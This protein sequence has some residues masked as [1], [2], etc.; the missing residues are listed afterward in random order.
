M[1][2]EKHAMFLVK[3]HIYFCA[4]TL[5]VS[6]QIKSNLIEVLSIIWLMQY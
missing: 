2:S 6:L 4:I 5:S 1:Q 3:M